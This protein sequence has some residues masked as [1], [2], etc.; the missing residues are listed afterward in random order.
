MD[1]QTSAPAKAILLGE[2]AVVYGMPAIAV[3]LS[4]VR[5]YAAYRFSGQPL[6]IRGDNASQLLFQWTAELIKHDD[7]L[8]AMIHAT[9]RYLGASELRGEIHIRSDIPVASGLGSGAAVSAALGRAV[10]ALQ[11]RSL[12]DQNLNDLVYEVEKLHHGTPSG[13]DNTVV[14]YEKPVY[15]VKNKA[16]EFLDI[17]DPINF[18]VADTGIAALTRHTVSD[19]RERY[20]RRQKQTQAVFD[21]IGDV[22]EQAR[23][24]VETGDSQKLGL[25]MTQNHELLQTLGVSSPALDR[26]VNAALSA[27]AFGTKLSGGGRGGNVIAVVD[28]SNLESVKD[29]MLAAGAKRVF[30]SSVG[31]DSS[32]P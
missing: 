6:T 5:T 3:P 26:L 29:S 31:S 17:A 15:Y 19:V 25:L 2:H 1:G 9:A 10:A 24:C 4:Q 13:I 20:V 18:L 30:A 32:M 27:G 16:L 21:K 28:D 8:A 14:V 12:L 7:P 11:R 22:T 23:I